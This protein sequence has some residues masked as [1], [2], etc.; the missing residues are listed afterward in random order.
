MS[1][2][3]RGRLESRLAGSLAPLFAAAGLALVVREWWPVAL[4]LLMLGVGVGLDAG[5]YHRLLSYQ[6]GWAAVPL[7]LLELGVLMGLVRVLGI[8]AHLGVALGLFAGAWAL[9]QLL[10]HAGFPLLR[11]EYAEH[12][13]ELG[14]IGAIGAAAALLFLATA[15]GVAWATQPPTVHLSAGVHQGPIVLDHSQVLAGAPGAI[16]RGGIRITSSDVTV[17]NVDVEGGEDGI[18]VDGGVDGI[19]NVVL[20]G[21]HV[22]GADLDG[23][24]V[25]RAQ[26]K[27]HDCSVFGTRSRYAQGIDISFTADLPASTV[28]NCTVVGG[29]E[30]IVTHMAMVDL[31]ENTVLGTTLRGITV[32]EMSMGMVDRNR[33]ENALG[34]GIFCGDSSE[35]EIESN[36]VSGTKP[37]VKSGDRLRRGIGIL[38]HFGATATLHDNSV[39]DSPGGI[40]SFADATIRHE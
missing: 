1:Y 40:A 20:E 9:A 14:S 32:T 13:G 12:G 25:R 10:A 5:V 33:V 11:L 31:M 35:C 30:G 22:R 17:R 6:P 18:T 37:D 24:H 4:A 2:T 7:G 26:V 19:R 3:L 36:L 8:P 38:A 21:V 15:G 28:E 16:V 39:L 23:I 34:I 29:Q 27:I